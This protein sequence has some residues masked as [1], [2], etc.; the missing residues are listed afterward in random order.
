LGQDQGVHHEVRTLTRWP[1]LN[2]PGLGG[3]P[4]RRAVVGRRNSHE[5]PKTQSG[6]TMVLQELKRLAPKA[7]PAIRSAEYV[8]ADHGRSLRPVDVMQQHLAN[9]PSANLNGKVHTGFI[10]E[11]PGEPRP[12]VLGEIGA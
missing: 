7:P 10:V 8:I 12:L 6:S 9:M 1:R 4:S 5:L 3:D 11:R 2:K